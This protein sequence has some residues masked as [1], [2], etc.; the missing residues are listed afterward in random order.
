MSSSMPFCISNS[1]TRAGQVAPPM[2]ASR[3]ALYRGEFRTD[4]CALDSVDCLSGASMT[5]EHRTPLTRAEP[6]SR[7]TLGFRYQ[8]CLRLLLLMMLG[9]VALAVSVKASDRKEDPPRF[10]QIVFAPDSDRLPA[11]ARSVFANVLLAVPFYIA[12]G[13]AMSAEVSFL[14]GCTPS[15]LSGAAKTA[16]ERGRRVV[17]A[18]RDLGLQEAVLTGWVAQMNGS[19]LSC[20]NPSDSVEYQTIDIEVSVRAVAEGWQPKYGPRRRSTRRLP[21]TDYDNPSGVGRFWT[22]RFEG[23]NVDFG[24]DQRRRTEAITKAA[25]AF[26]FAKMIILARPSRCPRDAVSDALSMLRAEKVQAAVLNN[27]VE[28]A[29]TRVQFVGDCPSTG[30]VEVYI[31]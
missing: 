17:E 6:P 5:R 31:R 4:Q 28:R 3:G 29:R 30:G 25:N 10:W 20:D 27:G 11:E 12:R 2:A 26:G 18:L 13:N 21:N 16:L 24:E 9:C 15:E 23:D 8:Y 1:S 19:A 22:I 14:A 7:G